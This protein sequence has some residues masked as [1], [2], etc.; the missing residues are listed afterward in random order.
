MIRKFPMTMMAAAVLLVAGCATQQDVDGLRGDVTKAKSAAEAAA[1]DARK[2]ADAANA[3][4]EAARKAADAA[5]A[6]AQK[7][8]RAFQKGLRK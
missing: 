8:D 1:A 7:A 4:A 6:A 3:A 5:N 2:A